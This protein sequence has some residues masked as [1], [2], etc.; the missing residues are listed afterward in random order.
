MKIRGKLKRC[1]HNT[2][3]FEI[4]Y[5][6][7]LELG[8]DY[9]LDIKPYKSSRSLEQNALAWLLISK[10]AEKTANDKWSIYCAALEQCN[11]EA[12]FILALP[13]TEKS[14]KQS[15]RV[16]IPLDET[17]EVNGKTLTIFKCYLGSSKF[18]SQQMKNFIDYLIQ[19]CSEE[20]IYIGEFI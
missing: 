3:S 18:N 14:L 9:T 20:G 6:V 5:N 11:Q 1:S 2:V 16:V 17:R 15:Y 8:K 4:P 12:E 7:E 19:V 10:L 13:Q